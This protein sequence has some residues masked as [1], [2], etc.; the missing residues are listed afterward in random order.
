MNRATRVA[1]IGVIDTRKGLSSHWVKAFM[2]YGNKHGNSASQDD[3]FR[4]RKMES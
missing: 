3:I 2:F 1:S 4:E